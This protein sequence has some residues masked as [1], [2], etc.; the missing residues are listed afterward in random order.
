[1]YVEH[2]RSHNCSEFAK[3]NIR[4]ETSKNREKIRRPCKIWNV[5]AQNIQDIKNTINILKIFNQD[6]LNYTKLIYKFDI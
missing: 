1:M 4:H 2:T 5:I 3:P 6:S